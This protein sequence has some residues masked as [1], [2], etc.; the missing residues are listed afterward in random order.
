LTFGGDDTKSGT[1]L[2]LFVSKQIIEKHGGRIWA[3]SEPGQWADFVFTLPVT[4]PAQSDG[5]N[6]GATRPA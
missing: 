4:P 1:G 3:E 2:G 5:V 6:A